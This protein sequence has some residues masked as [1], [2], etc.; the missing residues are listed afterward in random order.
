MYLNGWELCWTEESISQDFAVNVAQ[1][2]SVSNFA[3][4]T[5]EVPSPSGVKTIEC[6]SFLSPNTQ[7]TIISCGGGTITNN[8]AIEL[9]WLG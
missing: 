4:G 6:N 7:T 2:L 1:T 8:G 9:A 5:Y 3:S